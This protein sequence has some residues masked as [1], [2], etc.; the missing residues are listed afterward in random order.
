MLASCAKASTWTADA[1]LPSTRASMKDLSDACFCCSSKASRGCSEVG[2]EVPPA[3]P[4]TN[5]PLSALPPPWLLPGLFVDT[6]PRFRLVLGEEDP[7]AL[8]LRLA[9]GLL[10]ESSPRWRTVWPCN[11]RVAGV[12]PATACDASRA[13]RT[14]SREE[15]MIFLLLRWL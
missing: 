3:P 10:I 1:N 9:A 5:V 7:T 4:P 8:R 11:R 12:L 14:P 6:P 15:R 13:D 2:D